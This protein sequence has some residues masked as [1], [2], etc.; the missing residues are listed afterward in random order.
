MSGMFSH[1]KGLQFFSLDP[2]L[3]AGLRPYSC[4]NEVS[5]SFYTLRQNVRRF[6]SASAPQY[7]FNQHLDKLWRAEIAQKSG[8]PKPQL[9]QPKNWDR[10]LPQLLLHWAAS[11]DQS[12]F[13][14]GYPS[15]LRH[16]LL[17]IA[18]GMQRHLLES[19]DSDG[20]TSGDDTLQELVVD[21][22]AELRQLARACKPLSLLHDIGSKAVSLLHQL[23]PVLHEKGLCDQTG[24]TFS[25]WNAESL[26]IAIVVCAYVQLQPLFTV[27]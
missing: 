7:K 27:P 12:L 4:W 20:S 6:Y 26:H 8:K 10:D 19:E 2:L 16:H 21:V 23:Q 15:Y 25:K 13:P 1:L 3:L 5:R 18:A 22:L 14:T 24:V 11:S 17:G 9:T